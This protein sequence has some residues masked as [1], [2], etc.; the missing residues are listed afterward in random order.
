MLT[1]SPTY[2][3]LL[4]ECIGGLYKHRLFGDVNIHVSSAS[5]FDLHRCI[6]AA[7]C[8]RLHEI[9]NNSLDQ[10]CFNIVHP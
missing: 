9:L 4:A 10:V 6:L 8:S 5:F 3:L 7:R 2:F 1:T